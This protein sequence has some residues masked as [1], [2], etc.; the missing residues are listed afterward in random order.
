ML[1]TLVLIY[2][3]YILSTSKKIRGSKL[4][5]TLSSSYIAILDLLR[6]KNG[7]GT[8]LERI[9]NE[10]DYKRIINGFGLYLYLI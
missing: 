1:Y 10:T 7:F 8:D 4:R 9:I 5:R 2:S 6:S 3:F